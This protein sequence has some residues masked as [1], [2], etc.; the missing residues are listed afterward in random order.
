MPEMPNSRLLRSTLT[1]EI[2]RDIQTFKTF[3]NSPQNE[4]VIFRR[5]QASGLSICLIYLEGM[6]S[7]NQ[8]ADFILRATMECEVYIPGNPKCSVQF[9]LEKVLNIPQASALENVQKLVEGILGGMSAL[10]V[11]GCQ[12]ACLLETR[13]FEKR[14]VGKTQS[15][16][17]VS[18]SQEGFI[19][20]LRTNITL[21]RRYVQSPQL[22]TEK[23]RCR[24]K[25]PQGHRSFIHAR[26]SKRRLSSRN[27]PSYPE[28]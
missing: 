18:G 19:E 24:D 20:S 2:E 5:F 9:L 10:L 21:L 15:E 8:I 6:A 25:S 26:C 13:G 4:D 7:A 16:S 17:V 3:F 11:D 14:V 12:E 28:N 23:K 22:I 1:G 27:P